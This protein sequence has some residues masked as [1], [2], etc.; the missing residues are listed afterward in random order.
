[1]LAVNI[2]IKKCTSACSRGGALQIVSNAFFAVRGVCMQGSSVSSPKLSTIIVG[3]KTATFS[4]FIRQVKLKCIPKISY[5][6]SDWQ[7]DTCR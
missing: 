4:F 2:F 5:L 1:M 6:G 7:T 3:L